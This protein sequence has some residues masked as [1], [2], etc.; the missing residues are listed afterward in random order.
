MQIRF[1]PSRLRRIGHDQPRQRGGRVRG[2][3]WFGIRHV[4][5]N[6][7][8]RCHSRVSKLHSRSADALIPRC[9][10]SHILEGGKLGACF[11]WCVWAGPLGGG[12]EG[13]P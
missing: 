12:D 5:G 1:N 11:L 8:C 10:A 7:I 4:Q 2:V 6:E 13:G 3:G 9:H